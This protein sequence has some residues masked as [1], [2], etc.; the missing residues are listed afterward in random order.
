MVLKIASVMGRSFS[1]TVIQAV[2]PEDILEF[3]QVEVLH[4][5]ESLAKAGI[6]MENVKEHKYDPS[7]ITECDSILTI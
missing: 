5:L 3:Q 4:E 1:A 7:C 6:L 2:F